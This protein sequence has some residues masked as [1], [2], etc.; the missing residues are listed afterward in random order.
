M[1]TVGIRLSLVA[2]LATLIVAPGPSSRQ[3]L[4]AQTKSGTFLIGNVR[5]FDGE[6]T[7][8]GMNVVVED[9]II[10]VVETLRGSPL[11]R[12]THTEHSV[13]RRPWPALAR[14]RPLCSRG[15]PEVLT[16]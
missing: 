5:I 9:G 1:N 12:L 4:S 13:S 15:N 11:R 2:V 3:G 14:P 10:R 6:R 8:P 16:T 7:R